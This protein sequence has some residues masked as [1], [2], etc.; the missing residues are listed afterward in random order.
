MI[1]HNGVIIDRPK[2]TILHRGQ[3]KRF[4]QRA[5]GTPGFNVWEALLLGTWDRYR[6]FDMAYGDWI[7]GGPIAGEKMIDI[8]LSQWRFEFARMFL[9]LEK[10][11][12]GGLKFYRLVP[13]DVV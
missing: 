13:I 4:Y 10:D 7:D 5:L 6:L 8:R 3:R 9:R 12:R 1:R 11:K 2:T